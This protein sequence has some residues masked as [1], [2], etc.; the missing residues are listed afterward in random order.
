MIRLLL[1]LA[2]VALLAN[3][4]WHLFGCYA[5]NYRFKDR[6]QF[7]AE[8]RG[9]A[10]DDE[11]RDK[12]LSTAA[13]FEV[14]LTADDVTVSQQGQATV[15]DLSY[16]CPVEFAP[17]LKPY[18]LAFKVHVEGRPSRMDDLGFPK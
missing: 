16:T 14:P 4:G 11:V 3:A 5:P 2:V 12:I 15:V 13:E 7:I 10:T 1:K 6:V 17:G 9:K 18:L 8:H